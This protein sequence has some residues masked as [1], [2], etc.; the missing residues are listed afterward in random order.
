MLIGGWAGGDED[1]LALSG[2]ADTEPV[3]PRLGDQPGQ[4]RDGTRCE[5]VSS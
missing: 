3:N 2:V 4:P 5:P 1:A